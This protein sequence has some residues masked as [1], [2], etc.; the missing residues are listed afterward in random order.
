MPEPFKTFFNPTMVRSAADHIAR[1]QNGFDAAAFTRD[2]TVDFDRQELKERST[3]ITHA[4][5]RHL[6]ADFDAA[7]AALLAALHP[8][9]A[10]EMGQSVSDDAGIRGW[11]I[12]A[13]A[14]YVALRGLDNLDLSLKALR[15]MTTRFTAEFAVRP[16]LAADPDR[17]LAHVRQWVK[18]PSHHVRR[19]ASEGTRPRL[20]WSMRLHQFVKDPAPILPVL[21]ALKDDPEE[22]VRR[23]VANNLN[24]IAKDHPDLVAGIAARW[25]QGASRDRA[26]LVRHACR[27][28]IK[29]GHR[30]TLA[31]LG[32]GEAMIRLDEAT[33]QNP[34]VT[35]GTTLDLSATL[36]STAP[37]PQ[38]L[39]VDFS[40]FFRKANGQLAPK[41]FKWAMLELAPGETRQLR[42]SHPIRPIT[43]RRYYA[44]EQA[45]S[46]QING[47][48]L[49]KAPF[50]LQIPDE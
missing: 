4:L 26:R 45:V 2:A 1:H 49:F 32:Y 11:F 8:N 12:N 22:Y 44:G 48:T 9:P 34:H 16:F 33:V 25:M 50:F 27:T 40:V 39:I 42:K 31:A 47:K 13:M 20:P 23:S 29:Q 21:E 14:D 46:V 43:T 37:G 30:P 17:T 41:V 19:L 24:D 7:V 18:D 10:Q 3:A 28:L 36:T 5:D 38:K 6:P 35:F 15:A